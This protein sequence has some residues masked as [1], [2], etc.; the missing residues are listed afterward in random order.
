MLGGG[1]PDPGVAPG[2]RSEIPFLTR[3]SVL[4]YPP[5]WF[6]R[7][8]SF[9]KPPTRKSLTF[10]DHGAVFTQARYRH[11]HTVTCPGHATLSDLGVGVL[12]GQTR[13]ARR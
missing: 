7:L 1:L 9:G 2:G 12:P 11:A 3:G 13:L 10:L 4:E 8:D 6:V 5:R